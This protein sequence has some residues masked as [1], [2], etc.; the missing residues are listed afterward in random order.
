MPELRIDSGEVVVLHGPSG[1]G[2][3][4][5][6]LSLFG[7][8]DPGAFEAAGVVRF[9]QGA[10]PPPGS[11]GLRS[12]LREKVAVAMQDAKE[13]LDPLAPIG[14]QIGLV[15][16][17]GEPEIEAA[18]FEMGIEDPASLCGRLPH[19]ISTGQAQR[20][21]MAMAF[22]RRPA[23][24]LAD[25]PSASL[26]GGSFDELVQRLLLLRDRTGTAMLLATHDHRLIERLSARVIAHENGAFVPGKADPPSWPRRER[27]E[28]SRSAL[29]RATDLELRYGSRT[30]LRG[31]SFALHRGE[32]VALVGESGAG[33]TTLARA[34][35]GHLEPFAGRIERPARR[36]AVQLL[37][38]DA[39]SS[40]TPGRTV[41]SL[42]LESK[43]PCFDLSRQARALG[44]WESELDREAAALSGG[45]RRRAALLR[46]LSV[47]PEVLVLDEPTASLD[48]G[49][50][51]RVVEALIALQRERSLAL[52]LATHDIDLARALAD[53]VLRIEGG[54]LCA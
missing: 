27:A 31:A 39:L 53:S 40:L 12:I 42:V 9:A 10:V 7:L 33:K 15:A 11:S 14:L 23:L 22:L 5:L 26:D 49:A 21:L 24:L 54:R 47:N 52:L 29:L 44:L 19:E 30:V 4:S 2:K 38:Q 43:T 34:I 1:S 50:A 18:L 13:A 51:C 20:V 25:E 3:T 46:A 8:L 32:V 45:E 36:A 6:L 35:A 48:R 28:P 37:F 41:R 16:G 17:K